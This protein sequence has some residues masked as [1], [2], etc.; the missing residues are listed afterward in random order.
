MVFVHARFHVLDVFDRD[1]LVEVF[2]LNHVDLKLAVNVPS[3]C[4]VVRQLDGRLEI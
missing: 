1:Q 4:L 3:N 2:A